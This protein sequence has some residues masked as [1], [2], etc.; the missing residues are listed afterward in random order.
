MRKHKLPYPWWHAHEI[1]TRYMDIMAQAII[2][3]SL[4]LKNCKGPLLCSLKV[5]HNKLWKNPFWNFVTVYTNVSLQS[6]SGRSVSRSELP[7][8]YRLNSWYYPL[9]KTVHRQGW[10]L[11]NMLRNSHRLGCEKCAGY[12]IY[13]ACSNLLDKM[14]E[15]GKSMVVS[16]LLGIHLDH[17]LFNRI[18]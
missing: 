14:L 7:I 16:G 12:I 9:P 17:P 3:S 4:M 1:I 18:I 2:N 6:N 13:K 5:S 15:M 8:T 10:I 11:L